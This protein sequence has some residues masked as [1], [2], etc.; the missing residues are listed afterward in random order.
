MEKCKIGGRLGIW[1]IATIIVVLLG[2]GG[3]VFV[4]C[5][6]ECSGRLSAR[7][8]SS[9]F[10]FSVLIPTQKSRPLGDWPKTGKHPTEPASQQQRGRDRGRIDRMPSNFRFRLLLFVVR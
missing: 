2:L 5:L 3:S 1:I 9:L 6:E 4:V 10:L 7:F 8:V